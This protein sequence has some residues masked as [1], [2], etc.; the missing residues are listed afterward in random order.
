MKTPFLTIFLILSAMLCLSQSKIS[1]ALLDEMQQARASGTTVEALIVLDDSFDIQALDAELTRQKATCH[2]RGLAVVTALMEHA[3]RTQAELVSYLESRKGTDVV[4][5]QSFWIDNMILV[6]A[7]PQALLDI[8]QHRDV[9]QLEPNEQVELINPVMRQPAPRF[10]GHAE[11]G[12][13]AIHADKMWQ[14]GFTGE[15]VIVGLIDTGVEGTHPAVSGSWHGHAVPAA[16]AWNDPAYGTTVPTDTDGHGTH[17]TGILAG[18]DPNTSDTTGV[19]FGAEWICGRFGPGNVSA[20]LA[21]LQWIANPDGDPLTTD[22]I[23]AVVSNSWGD[24]PGS[25]TSGYLNGVQNLEAAGVAVVFAAGNSG[26]NPS[27]ICAPAKSNF[28]DLQVFSVGA[29][30]GNYDDLPIS[31]FSSR[32]PTTCTQG[33]DQIKPEVTAP[34]NH[35][36]SS[37]AGGYYVYMNGT[38]MATPHVAGAIALLKQAFP[39][40]TGHELKQMLYETARDLGEPGEDNTYGMGIIDVYQAFIENAVP[41]N[42]R[43]PDQATAYSDYTTPNAVNLSWI[44][45]TEL[46]N[47][48]PLSNF[49]IQIRRDNSLIASVP[50]G[51]GTYTDNGLT[52]GQQY[53]YS[54]NSLDLNTGY[55]S[56]NR[57]SIAWA[58]G[59][60]VPSAP[61]IL[62]G[63]YDP[64][65]G[66][67]ITWSDPTT[68]S[69][70][71]PI[72]DLVMIY[73]YRDQV[74][75]DS[76]P[77]GVESY[78][79]NDPLFE[80][81]YSY[82]LIAAD[83]EEPKNTSKASAP[84]DV[85]AGSR[86]DILV[87]YGNSYGPALDYVD[88]VYHAIRH[89]H[90]SVYKTNVLNKFGF[91][92]DH[93]AIFVVTGM[94]I[95]Y[96]H[97]L[98][99]QDG[100]M[101]SNY[102][103]NSGSVYIEGNM[104][105]NSASVMAGAYNIRPWLGLSS[106]DWTFDP[107]NQ[108]S[109][110]N[111]FSGLD[112]Q[113]PGLGQTWDIL[114]PST[115]TSTLWHDPDN[116]NIYGVY[117]EY[118]TGKIIGCV[119]P[120]GGM[121][122]PELPE[123]KPYL[124]C[125]YLEMLGVGVGCYVGEEELAGGGKQE[126]VSVYPNPAR[127]ISDIRYQISDIRYVVLNVYDIWGREIRTLVNK[128]QSP[129]EYTVSFDTSVLPAGI[130]VVRLETDGAF[131]STKMVVMK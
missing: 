94:Y 116:G 72:D 51:T 103:N 90:P 17:V 97:L 59:S 120:Y 28:T 18:L 87:Y 50:A 130:Y 26:P 101:L 19:A 38:S 111:A 99:S 126:A 1:D 44:D 113:Y 52:D 92:L 86:P 35:V 123:N 36:R 21:N 65:S 122:D 77:A 85:F 96:S 32:G 62:T 76:V 45:P 88:S 108:L 30:D 131:A 107:V 43:P 39:E 49:E 105:F 25:C 125:R 61:V 8:A 95:S 73:A 129:G 127:E 119:L 15:G 31:P 91:P 82:F 67:T 46:V 3:E 69:D 75:L 14:L 60:P 34:G 81:S 10:A 106:G 55:L 80:L 23:P 84:Y 16:Q 40:K 70:G 29:V 79:D 2:E 4:R 42:P 66:I 71:T 11:P 112:F 22:D 128:I 83:N 7:M 93:D 124:M 5:Y 78:T 48:D 9:T 27:T 56:I 6:E 100:S 104:C 118:N 109:G 12:L 57:S 33:G 102:L 24:T 74:L 37:W 98:N 68:Q 20:V 47:G 53:E 64:F 58:G 115:T 121:A 54:L 114:E 41:E 63:N 13:R 110:L 89:L 117:N